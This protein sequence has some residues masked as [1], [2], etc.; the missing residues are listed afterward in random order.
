MLLGTEGPRA[1]FHIRPG[2]PFARA[3]FNRCA[4]EQLCT[5]LGSTR[6]RPSFANANVAPYAMLGSPCPSI[7]LVMSACAV[8]CMRDPGASAFLRSYRHSSKIVGEVQFTQ[9]P[10]HVFQQRCN[11]I[12][13]GRAQE[14]PVQ[15]QNIQVSFGA[16]KHIDKFSSMLPRL[17]LL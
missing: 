16:Q 6:N 5:W 7:Y 3:D 2:R 10:R 15:F 11:G 4:S 8:C 17:Q 9:R 13:T 12:P 14:I 1:A